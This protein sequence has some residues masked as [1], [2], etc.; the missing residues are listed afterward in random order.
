MILI[1]LGG[2]LPSTVGSPASTIEAALAQLSARGIKVV[3]LSPFY[4]SDPVPA[5]D[6]PTFVN[7]AARIET[8]L[9]PEELLSLLHRVEDSFGRVRR[10]RNEAR[11]LDIDLLDYDGLRRNGEAGPV[12]PH[13]RL[14]LRAFVLMPLADIA[15]GWRHPVSG[16]SAAELL[17]AL[18]PEVRAGVRPM[19]PAVRPSPQP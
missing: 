2:N 8:S 15:P 18:S 7:V 3:A 1:G 17:A 6:Q 4:E 11:T 9:P 16:R 5:S 19:P 10:V 12:L 13:P 14:H